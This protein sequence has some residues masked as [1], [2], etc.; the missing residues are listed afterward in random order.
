MKDTRL[1]SIRKQKVLGG[2]HY[3]DEKEGF[4]G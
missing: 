4:R 1:G 3:K 2:V